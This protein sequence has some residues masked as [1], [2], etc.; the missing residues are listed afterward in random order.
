MLRRRLGNASMILLAPVWLAGILLF[1]VGLLP[2][3]LLWSDSVAAA[4]RELANRR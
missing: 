1:L 2:T 4:E 3:M